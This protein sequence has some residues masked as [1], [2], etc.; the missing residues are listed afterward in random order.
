M[1]ENNEIDLFFAHYDDGI[2][3]RAYELRDLVLE[4]LPDIIEQ[5]DIPARMAGYCY[6]Q[7][8]VDLICTIIP[9]K[10]GLKLSFNRGTELHD[11]TG[12]L[13]GSGK[14]S[15]YVEVKDSAQINSVAVRELL[16]AA[17]TLYRD[18]KQLQTEALKK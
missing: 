5:I 1:V 6:G 17:L 8:Y 18:K 11:P 4:M 15:R 16:S 13:Q 2:A 3:A 14:I 10:N 7:K 12:M 9:S